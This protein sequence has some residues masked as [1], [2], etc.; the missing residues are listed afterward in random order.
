MLNKVQ[1]NNFKKNGFIII[2]NFL[3]SHEIK[4]LQNS[5]DISREKKLKKEIYVSIDDQNIVDFL[6][7]K[8]LK[9]IL[10]LLIGPKVYFLHDTNVLDGPIYQTGAWHRDNPCRRTGI[11]PD[12]N[13]KEEYNVVS[14]AV[15]LCDSKKTQ[16]S[17]SVIPKSH[18]LNYSSKLSNILRVIHLRIKHLKFLTPIRK[19]IQFMIAKEVY[20][21][22]GDLVIF[23]C[24]LYH[25]GSITNISDKKVNREGVISRYGGEGKHYKNFM[26]YELNYRYGKEKFLLS[27][28]S[29]E[30][31]DRLKKNDIYV[32]P[33][34]KKK[35]IEGIFV[36]KNSASDHLIKK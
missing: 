28:N 4:A 36:P 5:V 20:Y 7:N 19:V 24:T 11:G 31:F 3:N 27:K 26:N 23:L 33:G 10:S 18:L 13:D 12:W 29:K 16:S 1:I 17:L 25:K 2:P 9:E 32:S 34:I 8:R 21:K 22:P 30:Y 15:Y 6:C 14:T 35:E